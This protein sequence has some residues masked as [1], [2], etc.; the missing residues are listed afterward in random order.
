MK[1]PDCDSLLLSLYHRE[2][3]E[4]ERRWIKVKVKYCK[5]CKRIVKM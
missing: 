4:P 2:G 5:Q 1:C 3:T